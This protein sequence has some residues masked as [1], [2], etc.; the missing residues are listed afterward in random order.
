MYAERQ[1]IYSSA[2]YSTIRQFLI[3]VPQNNEDRIEFLKN[4][5]LPLASKE[6][7]RATIQYP[8][9][10]EDNVTDKRLHTSLSDMLSKKPGA[11]RKAL[12]T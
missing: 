4:V 3:T 12:Q 1:P 6:I 11:P 8:S 5:L 2:Y 10:L 7:L 9:L